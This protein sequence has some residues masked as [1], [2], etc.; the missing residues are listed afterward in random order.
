MKSS[1]IVVLA[2]V[3]LGASA[4]ACGP[5][6]LQTATPSVLRE[7]IRIAHEACQKGDSASCT[8]EAYLKSRYS[9]E[10]MREQKCHEGGYVTG[11]CVD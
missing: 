11:Y 5:T 2:L 1:E 7:K 8:D 9:Y 10:L 6:Q 3:L 4:A